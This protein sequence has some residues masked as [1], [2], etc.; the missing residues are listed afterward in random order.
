MSQDVIAISKI[1][2]RDLDIVGKHA[3]E[4]G[5]LS[6]IGIPVPEGFVVTSSCFRK[7]LDDNKLNLAI[8]AEKE[9]INASISKDIVS[10]I[11]RAYK[12]LGS[13]FKESKVVLSLS[14]P[15]R[16][17]NIRFEIKGDAN[18]IHK[19]K[20]IW[21]SQFGKISLLENGIS[22][23]NDLHMLDIAIVVQKKIDSEKNGRI[24]TE[25]PMT[26]DKTKIVIEQDRNVSHYLISKRSLDVIFKGHLSKTMKYH[27]ISNHEAIELASL[28]R[29][30]E[31]HF[32]FPQEV[33]F[34][35]DK[36]KFYIL[37]SK[38]MTAIASKPSP[39][40]ASSA[41]ALSKTKIAGN[42][43]VNPKL[44]KRESVLKGTSVFPGIATGPVRVYK[45]HKSI[46]SSI[47][48][49][50]LVLPKI[51]MSLLPIVKKAKGLIIEKTFF[52]DHDKMIYRR[53]FAKPVIQ[54]AKNATI[55][56]RSG[57]VV[58]V[59]GQKGE[60]YKGGLN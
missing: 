48:S 26:S 35:I 54:G 49:E 39:G 60:I 8:P 42:T 15:F 12:K 16:L 43:K 47:A 30:I 17:T 34:T 46:H 53:F 33:R 37:D 23:S 38:P 56:L 19:I 36:N 50:I 58:T 7:F 55:I 10:Q 29:N 5:E 2:K 20:E 25:D 4:L 13:V 22:N 41:I 9:I 32:Y 57:N 11:Y 21:A 24:F 45:N 40:I 44:T 1:D 59:D 6:R 27:K 18:L 28:G 3:V 31:K 14:S 51:D 52:S